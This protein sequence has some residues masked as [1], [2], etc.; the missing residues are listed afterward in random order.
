MNLEG[1]II[2]SFQNGVV[3]DIQIE[4]YA[5]SQEVERWGRKLGDIDQ[6]DGEFIKGVRI[7]QNKAIARWRSL[8]RED[9]L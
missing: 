9:S 2:L 7:L 8:S 6:Y 1:L 4:H 5:D 3:V